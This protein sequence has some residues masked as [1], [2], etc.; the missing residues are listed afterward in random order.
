[1]P[2]LLSRLVAELPRTLAVRVAGGSP[3]ALV[4]HAWHLA[5][6]E[7]EGYGVRITRILTEVAPVLPDFDGERIARERQYLA[8]DAALGAAV[9]ADARR[10]NVARL[11]AL[12]ERSLGRAG[13]QEGVGTVSVADVATMM[14]GHDRVHAGQLLQL[15]EALA[16]T[17]SVREALAR[18]AAAAPDE[19]ALPDRAL[20]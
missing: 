12:D 13:V 1:M 6:L 7:R 16:P 10:H 17:V 5:D 8:A 4:E 3:L 18:R 9:F 14:D 2:T 20:A 11:Q 15:V 19:R